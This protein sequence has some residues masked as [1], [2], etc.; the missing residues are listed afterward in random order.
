M[1]NLLPNESKALILDQL[2]QNSPKEYKNLQESNQLKEYVELK[3]KNLH[4]LYDQIAEQNPNL[5]PQHIREFVL[6]E[7]R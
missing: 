4:D 1:L 5:H 2:K 6:A 3:L 7:F